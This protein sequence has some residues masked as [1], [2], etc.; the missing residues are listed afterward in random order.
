MGIL[1]SYINRYQ[2]IFRKAL[3]EAKRK[4]MIGVR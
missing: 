3:K 4:E 2:S 1:Q